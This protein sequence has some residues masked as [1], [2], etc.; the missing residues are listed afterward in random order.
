MTDEKRLQQMKKKPTLNDMAKPNMSKNAQVVFRV[1]MAR[2][3]KDQDK[4]LKKAAT[5]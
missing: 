3:K 5:L 2:A 4:L 1:A